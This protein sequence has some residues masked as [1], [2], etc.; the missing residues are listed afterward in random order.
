MIRLSM[1]QLERLCQPLRHGNL[2]TVYPLLRCLVDE[3]MV[4]L[5]HFGSYLEM[6]RSRPPRV[7]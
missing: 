1:E 5:R 6:L 7:V 3:E 2:Q 4:I